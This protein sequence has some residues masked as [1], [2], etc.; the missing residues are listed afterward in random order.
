VLV[1]LPGLHG[2]WTLVGGFRAALGD[3]VTFVETTYPRTLD[4]SLA[5]YAEAIEDALFAESITDGWLLAESFGSQVFWALASRRRFRVQGGILAGGFVRHPFRL[6][7]RATERAVG[8]LPLSV[9]TAILFGYA[10]IARFRY[11]RSPEA[12]GQLQEFIDRRTELDRQAAKHR[13]RLIAA[14]DPREAAQ[15][16]QIPLYGITG[17]WDPI[18]PWMLVRPWLK[19][20][21]PALREF[22]LVY[23]SDHNVLSNAPQVAAQAI[24]DWMSHREEPQGA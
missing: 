10:R 3:R 16:L 13:L 18:V 15:N 1:Y 20:H 22:R 7:V 17:V 23:G 19:R 4:W 2:D 9:I 5:E 6:G 24:A 14:N 8:D 12:L 21:C 11:R